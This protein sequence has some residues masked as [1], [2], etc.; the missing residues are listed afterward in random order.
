MVTGLAMTGALAS[1][2]NGAYADSV[3]DLNQQLQTL[4]KDAE[5]VGLKVVIKNAK[6]HDTNTNATTDAKHEV[7]RIQKAIETVGSTQKT[8]ATLIENVDK[9]GIKLEGTKTIEIDA[10]NT[11]DI[12]QKLKDLDTTF[13]E[14]LSKKSTSDKN[15]QTATDSAR[16]AGVIVETKGTTTVTDKELD[17][18]VNQMIQELSD[19]EK[20]QKEN[21]ANYQKAVADWEKTVADGHAKVESDYNSALSKWNKE[22]AD[23]H[24][25]VEKEYQDALKAWESK[26]AEDKAKIEQEYQDALKDWES[27][28]AEGKA[29]VDTKNANA[30]KAWETQVAEGKAKV[31]KEYQD[32]LTQWK[33]KVDAEKPS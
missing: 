3:T 17:G 23:G 2:F 22:V 1:A 11:D 16:Q 33:A 12:N 24:A 9:Q 25:K 10:T 18:V 32:A 6:V 30:L 31:E 21:Q 26:V 5:K 14:I 15:L 27:K 20:A 29:Q 19:A 4:S 7:S 13:K 8:L 28:V